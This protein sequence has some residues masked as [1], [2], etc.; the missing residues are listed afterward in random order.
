[1]RA[2]RAVR[3]ACVRLNARACKQT[4]AGCSLSLWFALVVCFLCL[5]CGLARRGPTSRATA[6]VP[7]HS[8]PQGARGLPDRHAARAAAAAGRRARHGRR[9]RP[10]RARPLRRAAG[11]GR[12]GWRAR[13][14]G[15]V[16]RSRTLP[17]R[18]LAGGAAGCGWDAGARREV[19]QRKPWVAARGEQLAAPVGVS[20]VGSWCGGCRRPALGGRSR[21]ERAE[22]KSTK[23]PRAEAL[24]SAACRPRG[25]LMC[26]QRQA[27]AEGLAALEP[28]AEDIP[29]W[30]A[31]AGAC[32]PRGRDPAIGPW[33]GPA[34]CAQLRCSDPP[35]FA[36]PL[37]GG[38]QPRAR[39]S[40]R[41]GQEQKDDRKKARPSR[42]C[43]PPRAGLYDGFLQ[44]FGGQ[45]AGPRAAASAASL[46]APPEGVTF[47]QLGSFAAEVRDAGR[48]LARTPFLTG[49]APSAEL[50]VE[51]LRRATPRC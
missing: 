31:G 39:Q 37:L 29:D 33:R 50:T 13:A 28:A 48:F 27:L 26:L 7:T 38:L 14:V 32:G 51:R 49:K 12:A 19:L 43:A 46:S 15:G 5:V 42:R 3:A 36:P 4:A 16:H 17:G 47:A 23:G 44:L 1:V 45:A 20:D 11:R 21:Y 40:L 25:P 34:L 9:V 2:A 35:S 22:P 8:N 18:R 6:R 24:M 10:R 30:R 41:R